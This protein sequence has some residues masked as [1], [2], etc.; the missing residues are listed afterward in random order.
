MEDQ[1]LAPISQLPLP[2]YPIHTMQTSRRKDESV[3]CHAMSAEE[4]DTHMKR[5]FVSGDCAWCEWFG[6]SIAGEKHE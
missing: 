4:L 3:F 1:V 6:R 2:F 5:P